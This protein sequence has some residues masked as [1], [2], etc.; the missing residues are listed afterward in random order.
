MESKFEIS[1]DILGHEEK[2]E[3]VAKVL[4]RIITVTAEGYTYEADARHAEMIIRD[5]G[6]RVVDGGG[7]SNCWLRVCVNWGSRS[8]RTSVSRLL[9]MQGVLAFTSTTH[10]GKMSISTSLTQCGRGESEQPPMLGVT[11]ATAG[12]RT[13]T[14]SATR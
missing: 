7:Q 14:C 4:N 1:T 3:K 8:D 5:L 12:L 2:D 6:L 13:M 10:R 11:L 9:L